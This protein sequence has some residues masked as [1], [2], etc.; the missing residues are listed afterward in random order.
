MIDIQH[1]RSR[2]DQEFTGECHLTSDE[3][4]LL[5]DVYEAACSWAARRDQESA[6]RLLA[7]VDNASRKKT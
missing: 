3:A 5:F 4:R 2:I 7:T 6:A 1:L